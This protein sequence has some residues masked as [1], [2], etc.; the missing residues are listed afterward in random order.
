MQRMDLSMED[1]I[2][3]YLEMGVTVLTVWTWQ[4]QDPIHREEC[5][6]FLSLSMD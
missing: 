1:A 5:I 2:E 3:E 6:P 4:L